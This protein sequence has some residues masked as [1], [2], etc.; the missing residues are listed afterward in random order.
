MQKTA[1]ADSPTSGILDLLHHDHEEV[2]DLFEKICEGLDEASLVVTFEEL[3]IALLA[4][5]EAEQKCF[6][7]RLLKED[8]ESRFFALKADVEHGLVDTLLGRLQSS[9]AK[10]SDEWLAQCIVLKELVEHHIEEEEGEGFEIARE[11]FDDKG[12]ESLGAEFER[13]KKRLMKA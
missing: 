6:Y 10:G 8:D 1:D 5:A 3:R 9:T 11:I 13:E 7:G 12:L 4:H 2:K